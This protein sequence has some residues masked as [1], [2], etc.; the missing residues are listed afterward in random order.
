MAREPITNTRKLH[1][2]SVFDIINSGPNHRFTIR[3]ADKQPLLVHNC[4][5]AMARIVISDQLLE[6][7]RRGIR[8]VSSTHDELIAVCPES[9]ADAVLSTMIEVMS[10]TPKWADLPDYPK[11]TLG[12]EGGYARNYSK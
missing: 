8:T 12:A 10:T 11:L 6:V 5:Q 1:E 9:E 2:S 7:E 4:V 3:G